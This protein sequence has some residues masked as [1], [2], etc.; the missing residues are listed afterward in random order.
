[1]Q[2]FVLFYFTFHLMIC[3]RWP[4][5][6][7]QFCL[8]R[9]APALE[10]SLWMKSPSSKGSRY[11]FILNRSL[12]MMTID[13]PDVGGR[14]HSFIHLHLNWVAG[15]VDHLGHSLGD[16]HQQLDEHRAH[17]LV[18][19]HGDQHQLHRGR[20]QLPGFHSL[21]DH[22]STS[23]RDTAFRLGPNEIELFQKENSF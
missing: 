21:C 6:S 23:H 4:R 18:G 2:R 1:M 7:H 13:S 11:L 16:E 20:D 10:A 5:W 17:L 3:I 9:A 22:G 12:I 15:G 19:H 8:E 14:R